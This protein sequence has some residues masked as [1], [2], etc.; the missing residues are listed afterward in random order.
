MSQLLID[1]SLS[2]QKSIYWKLTPAFYVI[3]FLYI[4]S[5]Y[6]SNYLP[7]LP[8]LVRYLFKTILFSIPYIGSLIIFGKLQLNIVLTFLPAQILTMVGC[9][10]WCVITEIDPEVGQDTKIWVKGG[11][12]GV[13][14]GIIALVLQQ[15]D[16]IT[17]S[18]A[19][20]FVLFFLVVLLRKSMKK[21]EE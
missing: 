3:V 17:Y 13:I 1:E 8:S 11:I 2:K 10:L 5:V 15:P 19:V 12:L 6:K 4:T 16:Y 21:L 9:Y 7:I 14:G 18:I 20:L